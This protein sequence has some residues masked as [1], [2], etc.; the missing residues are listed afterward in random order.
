MVLALEG[1][2]TITRTCLPPPVE[3]GAPRGWRVPAP[4]PLPAGFLRAGGSP[5]SGACFLRG[6]TAVSWVYG[7]VKDQEQTAETERGSP[8]SFG[9]ARA[10]FPVLGVAVVL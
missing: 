6:G 4:P 2:S 3:G 10:V 8:G 5:D 7:N 1:D 9:P